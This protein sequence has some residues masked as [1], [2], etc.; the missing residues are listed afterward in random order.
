M[1]TFVPVY[2][3]V[4]FVIVI[5]HRTKVPML[6]DV[7]PDVM[8]FAFTSIAQAARQINVSSPAKFLHRAVGADRNRLLVLHRRLGLRLALVLAEQT[9]L[10]RR[11]L[12]S[13]LRVGVLVVLTLFDSLHV[14]GLLLHSLLLLT[15]GSRGGRGGVGDCLAREKFSIGR[16]LGSVDV[17][18][19]RLLRFSSDAIPIPHQALLVL[20]LLC[21][22]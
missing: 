16:I 10:A 15:V 4:I 2:V 18:F 11:L 13:L 17:D 5:V 9:A 1:F 7:A 20:R 8:V 19:S 22:H 12:V 6:V 21:V 3:V 14:H